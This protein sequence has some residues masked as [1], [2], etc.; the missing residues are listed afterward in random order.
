MFCCACTIPLGKQTC[1]MIGKK[2]IAKRLVDT[3]QILAGKV[4]PVVILTAEFDSMR[5]SSREARDLYQKNGTLIQ[6][7]ELGGGYHCSWM[8]FSMA[9]ADVWY[10]DF[11]RLTRFYLD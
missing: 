1:K 8:N 9:Q 6:H 11:T 4:P 7:I 5:H 2:A 10:K 3:V